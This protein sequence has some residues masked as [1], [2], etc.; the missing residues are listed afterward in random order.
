M[1]TLQ[2]GQ[3]ENA[4]RMGGANDVSAKQMVQS[5][6]NCAQPLEHRANVDL[7]KPVVNYFPTTPP[8]ANLPATNNVSFSYPFTHKDV[9]VNVPPFQMMEWKP[10]PYIPM[11]P[12]EQAQYPPWPQYG[13][14][15]LDGTPTL[16]VPGGANLGTIVTKKLSA[17]EVHAQTLDVDGDARVRG[18]LRVDGD[19]DTGGDVRVGGNLTVNGDTIL[20]GPV[21]MTGP[22]VIAGTS[23]AP[24]IVKAVSDVYWEG[25]ALKATVKTYRL[26]G[27]I[28]RTES[29]TV[30]EG[31]ECP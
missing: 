16:K 6:A 7:T 20:N 29:R 27:A 1:Y 25:G 4:L 26:F 3:I 24:V 13:W 18:G 14:E 19:I 8:A 21:E 15:E 2:S 5:L 12:W 22:L 23:L 11:P 30:V 10:I 28:Q 9:Y 17:G 31:T